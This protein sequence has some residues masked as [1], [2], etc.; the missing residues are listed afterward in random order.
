MLHLS[1]LSFPA[2]SPKQGSRPNSKSQNLIGEQ[3]RQAKQNPLW[4]VVLLLATLILGNAKIFAGLPLEDADG[5]E[6]PSLAPLLK[7]IN[8]AVVN[9][10]TYTTRRV[11]QN[12]LLNDPFFR[13]FFNV[14]EQQAPQ[15]R[16]R[17]QSA[18]SGV[19][20]DAKA[21]TVVTN[22]HVIK[23]ADEIVVGLEDGRTFTAELIGS[24]EEVDIA[25]LKIDPVR[26]SQL[27]IANSDELQ[28]GDFV[29]AVGNPFGLSHSVTTGVIS[30]LGRSG[31][32]IESYENFIQ[33]DAAINPGNSG[34]ALVNLRGELIGI[35][36]AIIGPGGGNAG[37]GFA[38]PT[39]MANASINQILEHGEVKRGRI[40]VVIQDLTPELAEAFDIDRD[41]R[42]VLIAEVKED[43]EADKAGLESGD[44]VTGIN[45]KAIRSTAQLR[46]A[47]G[48]RRIG[49]S[50]KLTVLREG[51]EKQIKVKIG[52]TEE[53]LMSSSS[54]IHPYL[55][56][57]LLENS[58]DD[59]GVVVKSIDNDAPAASSGLRPG[60]LIVASNRMR[61]R[62]L[63]DL[64]KSISGKDKRI[65]LRIQRGRAALYL[66]L[67]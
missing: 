36:T 48:V 67:Q 13:R 51:K 42:G 22:A 23:D 52:D 31:L 27:S 9:I 38:I 65:L 55:E 25:V 19:I 18:G 2:I 3:G 6:L 7:Q 29:I 10:S 33:T 50:L 17:T 28:A 44:I 11:A 58:D 64:K 43:S 49:E 45:G 24:D 60:A 8:P 26:L 66:V 16:R 61:I 53:L 46:N 15:P 35:N 20:I 57:A 4:I 47:V 63:P 41:Q 59:N 37:I 40:G 12:P 56:G 5:R 1:N 62:S 14:P 34:G 39:N 32:G 30:A 21:G 54:A